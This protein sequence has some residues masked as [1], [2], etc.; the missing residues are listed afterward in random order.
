MLAKFS[1]SPLDAPFPSLQNRA[2]R[3]AHTVQLA[4]I[5]ELCAEAVPKRPC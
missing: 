1:F 2:A 4:Y 5:E 3:K